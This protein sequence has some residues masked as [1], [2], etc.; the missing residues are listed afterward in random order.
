MSFQ[1]TAQITHDWW[2]SNWLP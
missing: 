1:E 2:E